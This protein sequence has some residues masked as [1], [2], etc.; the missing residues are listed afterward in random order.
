MLIACYGLLLDVF[1]IVIVVVCRE[2]LKISFDPA[3]KTRKKSETVS[4][5]Y[6]N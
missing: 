6:I 5:R 1:A 3:K 4:R 2:I